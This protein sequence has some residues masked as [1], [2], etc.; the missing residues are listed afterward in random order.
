MLVIVSGGLDHKVCF[1]KIGDLKPWNML[2]LAVGK[3]EMGDKGGLVGEGKNYVI[4]ED[5][6]GVEFSNRF[7]LGQYSNARTNLHDY[8]FS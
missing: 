4:D 8:G 7:S 2:Q 5:K 6:N 3:E 1:D